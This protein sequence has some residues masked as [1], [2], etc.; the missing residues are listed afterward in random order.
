MIFEL[1]STAAMG[2]LAL[3]AHLA[4][5][6]AGNDSKKLAKLFALSGLNV[7]DG[8]QTLTTQLLKKRTYEWGTEYRYRIPLGRSFDDYMAKRHTIEAGINTRRVKVSLKDLRD[9]R[10]DR[11]ILRELKS[12]YSRK[13]TARKE[14]ELSYDGVLVVRIYDEPLPSAVTF[15]TGKDWRVYFGQT[16]EKNSD[17]WHDF[18]VIPHLALGGATRYGKSNLINAI[19]SSLI[20]QQP[21][22]V[23][24][25]LVDLKGGIELCDY[26]NTRQVVSIAY[27]PE[28]ALETLR[29]AYE[30]MR[31]TQATLRRLGK[32]KVQ[33]AGIPTRHFI[34][35]DEVGEL[36]PDE[37]VTKE[38]RALKAECQ[39]FMSKIAR[40]GAGLGFRQILATQYPTGDVI[41]RQCKQNSDAKLCFRVQS[42]IASRV[43]LDRDGAEQLPQV[44]GRAMYLTP[45]GMTTIQTPLITSDIIEAT[46]APHII[47]KGGGS[48]VEP[49]PRSDITVFEETRLS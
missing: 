40:L 48:I 30:A 42:A 37:A 29:G 11:N 20:R 17:T 10:L 34:V 13:L 45:D 44:R 8:K 16:R 31:E 4:K 5:S 47:D 43:V 25:H 6:G 24:F 1:L 18:E 33:D 2:G 19:V 21:D 27:E 15:Q 32:K 22:N 3:R 23:R 26:E 9:L 7:R 36:N 49:A 12:I 46:I 14:V 39:T 35:I 28:E 41:P 38:E